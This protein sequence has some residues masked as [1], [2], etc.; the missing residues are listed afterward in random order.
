VTTP[1]ASAETI[2]ALQ[3]AVTAEHAAVYGYSAGG[4]HLSVNR[5]PV[6]VSYFVAHSSARDALTAALRGR[7]GKAP[8]AL[9]GY[10]V[11]VL[12]TGVAAATFLATLDDATA[13]AYAGILG[14]TADPALRRL[15][16]AGLTASATR[17]TSWRIAAGV[18]PAVRPFPGIAGTPG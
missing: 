4:G 11:P 16:V 6:A 8:A 1:V 5:R 15:A 14:T 2:K 10:T 18:T 17:A 9:R 13:A 7:G 3:L 12:A